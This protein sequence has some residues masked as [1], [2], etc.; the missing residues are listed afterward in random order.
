MGG[1]DWS[2]EKSSYT[3]PIIKSGLGGGPIPLMPPIDPGGDDPKGNHESIRLQ[4]GV[5]TMARI[6]IVDLP[7]DMKVSR[8]E[9][10]KITGAGSTLQG[11]NLQGRTLQGQSLQGTSYQGVTLQATSYTPLVYCSLE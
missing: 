7:K 3:D 8:E 4:E 6:K 2:R 5:V 1:F 11:R 9:M 10:K